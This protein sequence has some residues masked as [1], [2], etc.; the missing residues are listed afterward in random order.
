ML[1]E[2]G[3]ESLLATLTRDSQTMQRKIQEQYLAKPSSLI[4]RSKR[5]GGYSEPPF[6]ET[7]L[8]SILNYPRR[9]CGKVFLGL[10]QFAGCNKPLYKQEESIKLSILLHVEF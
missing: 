3:K 4:L 10:L 9:S 7:S 5:V 6:S 1:Y 8:I 2:D